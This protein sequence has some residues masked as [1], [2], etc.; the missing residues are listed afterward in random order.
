MN[1]HGEYISVTISPDH[2]GSVGQT[3]MNDLARGTTLIM[4]RVGCSLTA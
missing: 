4:R 3:M 2:K 1:A